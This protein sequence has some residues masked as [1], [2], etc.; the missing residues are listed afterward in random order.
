MS[1]GLLVG[2]IVTA[3]GATAGGSILAAYFLPELMPRLFALWIVFPLCMGIGLAT[4][5]MFA[6]RAGAAPLM[7]L[8][9]HFLAILGVVAGALAM[10]ALLNL[11]TTSLPIGPLWFLLAAAMPVGLMLFNAGKIVSEA[12]QRE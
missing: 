1:P 5:M 7:R 6:S 3:F 12:G 9:G 10:A 11:W 8:A 2:W 4:A